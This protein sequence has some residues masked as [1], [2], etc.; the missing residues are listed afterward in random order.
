[1]PDADGLRWPVKPQEL[2]RLL[3]VPGSN[4]PR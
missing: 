2:A 3:A 4:M 1:M